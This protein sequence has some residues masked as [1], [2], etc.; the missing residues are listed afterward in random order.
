MTGFI[1]RISGYYIDRMEAYLLGGYCD[2]AMAMPGL[3]TLQL[4]RP[5]S[6]NKE[7]CRIENT[8]PNGVFQ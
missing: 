3:R 2:I 4:L 8:M 6:P 7:V 5:A 1:R